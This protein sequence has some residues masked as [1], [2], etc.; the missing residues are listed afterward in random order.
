MTR[1]V[2]ILGGYGVFGGRLAAALSKITEFDVV[3]AGRRREE[4]IK[5]CEG[6]NCRPLVVD[7]RSAGLKAALAAERPFAVI[8]A[9][10][11]FQHYGDDPYRIARAAI[12][13]GA[14]YIDLSD[15]AG[16]T[17]N[18]MELD[19]DASSAG[20]ALLS[21]ASSVP[22]L[23]SAA[24]ATLA[25]GLVD[26]HLIE[27]VILPGNRAPRG[28]SVVRAIAAQAGKPMKIWRGGKFE[29]VPGWSGRKVITLDAGRGAALRGRWASFIGAPDLALFPA[30]FKARTVLFRA[31]L[32]LK[33]L[34]GGLGA[35]SWFVRLRIIESLSLFAPFLKS[36][37]DLFAPLG[38]NAG[39][40]QVEVAGLNADGRA[41]R[42]RWTLI[43]REGDGPNIPAIPAQIL[44]SKLLAGEIA[45]GARP[46]LGAFTL[47]EAERA[48]AP[49]HAETNITTTS[50]PPVFEKALGAETF[51]A[52]PEPIRNLHQVI[53][54]RRWEGRSSITR[55]KG[56]L[57]ILAGMVAGFPPAAGDVPVT[58]EMRRTPSGER[59]TRRFDETEFRS[60]LSADPDGAAG[61]IRERFGL[62][63]CNIDLALRDGRLAYPVVGGRLLG[64]P[65]PKFLLPVSKTH[66]Y[67]DDKGRACF[68]VTVSLP[69]GGHV[70]TYKG[71]LKPV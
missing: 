4:A 44:C 70:A 53:E 55:G 8:D 62:M 30:H 51:A 45:P 39:G 67:V 48:M 42:R 21:G 31:G 46:C 16:F 41:E 33:L 40:M 2:I 9:A 18:I 52:L 7:I 34:H 68:D 66:E 38:S 5:F 24:V 20:V 37:A 60:H 47:D 26:I 32:D 25:Q 15:D 56:L 10:G 29:Q 57:A 1:T 61:R 27:S 14:H 36:I 58:V 59:W 19:E 43:V 13:C 28:L 6:K 23:S 3:V 69:L 71:W 50:E 63:T 35:L 17:G 11:P 54:T 49:L 64:V 12:A 22:A 65:I